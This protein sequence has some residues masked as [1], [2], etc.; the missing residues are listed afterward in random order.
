MGGSWMGEGAAESE[1]PQAGRG[2]ARCD[3]AEIASPLA[4]EDVAK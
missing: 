3:A 1:Q 4:G 2:E